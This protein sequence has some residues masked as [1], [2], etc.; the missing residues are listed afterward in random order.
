M[1]GKRVDVMLLR[2]HILSQLVQEG[3]EEDHSIPHRVLQLSY[4]LWG[5][6]LGFKWEE[7]KEGIGILLLFCNRLWL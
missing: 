2:L 4:A 1:F 5:E 6:M 3:L 7:R